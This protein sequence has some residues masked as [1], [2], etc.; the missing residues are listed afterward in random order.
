M[1]LPLIKVAAL[2]IKSASKPIAK[3]VKAHAAHNPRFTAAIMTTAQAWNRIEGKLALFVGER[4]GE[5]RPLNV[6]AAIDLG[7]EIASEFFLLS[8]AVGLLVIENMRSSAKDA[9]KAAELN[10][11]FITLQSQIDRQAEQIRVFKRK[12]NIP[13]D[14]DVPSS[15]AID[16]SSA[17]ST[18]TTTTLATPESS[19][20]STQTPTSTPTVSSAA[21]S[22]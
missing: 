11:K 15:A 22:S 10:Q 12:L 5:A 4:I 2:V 8:V 3:Q 20:S 9:A 13:D 18:T 19:S 16:A 6:N 7:A 14:E 1:V 21:P 17:S